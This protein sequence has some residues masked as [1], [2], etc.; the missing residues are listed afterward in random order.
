MKNLTALI[1]ILSFGLSGCET[2]S[3]DEVSGDALTTK[4]VMSV[5]EMGEVKSLDDVYK[6]AYDAA[7]ATITYETAASHL[8]SI[9]TEIQKELNEVGQ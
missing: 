5:R 1:W 7:K 4:S 8:D 9:E 2:S 3:V 6:L